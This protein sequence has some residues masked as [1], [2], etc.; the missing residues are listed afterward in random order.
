M[1]GVINAGIMT[2]WYNKNKEYEKG[3]HVDYEVEKLIEIM[4]IVIRE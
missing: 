3:I 1:L 2:C 4:D